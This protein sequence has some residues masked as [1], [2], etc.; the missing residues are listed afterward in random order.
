MIIQHCFNIY[1]TKVF[2]VPLE[3]TVSCMALVVLITGDMIVARIT[4]IWYRQ[5]HIYMTHSYIYIHIYI[6]EK[7]THAMD[8]S[9][10]L[11]IP[12]CELHV[13]D[14]TYSRQIA[15]DMIGL[16]TL[17]VKDYMYSRLTE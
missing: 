17:H 2:Y 6:Y 9:F 11:S 15:W 4:C 12:R 13:K 1:L 5:I 3:I 14:Y 7:A 10:A 8:T 16:L